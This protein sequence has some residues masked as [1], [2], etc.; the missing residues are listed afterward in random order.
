LAAFGWSLTA[1]A[2][3]ELG[4]GFAGVT[5]ALMPLATFPAEISTLPSALAD[6]LS[7]APAGF[8]PIAMGLALTLI[9]FISIPVTNTSVN[10]ARSAGVAFFCRNCRLK[11]ALAVVGCAHY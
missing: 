1:A 5:L 8:A 6:G 3:P 4:I 7:G 10:P 9:H 11:L 2:F